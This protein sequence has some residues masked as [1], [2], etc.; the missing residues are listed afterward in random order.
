MTRRA[1]AVGR[2]RADQAVA[3]RAAALERRA[4][5]LAALANRGVAGLAPLA[6]APT[7][8]SLAELQVVAPS[9]ALGSRSAGLILAEGD[10][11]FDYPL[12][13]VL[14]LLEDVH[15]YD[16]ECLARASDRIENMAYASGQL[17]TLSRRLERLLRDGRAPKAILLSGGGNDV[18]GPEFGM[19]LNHAASKLPGL[20]E[21]VVEG[22]I[23]VRI[24]SAYV[25][26]LAAVTRLCQTWLKRPLPILLHGYDYPVPDG[27]G[28][29][30]GWG[31]LPGPWLEPGFLEKGYGHLEDRKA[32]AKQ[33]I[34]RFNL[35]LAGVAAAPEFGHVTYVNLRGTLSAGADYEDHWGNEMHPTARG[36]EM[37][38]GSFAEVL[39]RF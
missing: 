25:T 32:I 26:I 35:M 12:Y 16:V 19:L 8:P 7:L 29:F 15:G 27:R 24:R 9:F 13:D 14:D 18:V 2:Q 3:M 28:V 36:F 10:S 5:A 11:W 6:R 33:L 17:E 34:D 21:A 37:I 23:D 4:E 31:P 22:V 39:R 1:M 30:G 38:A 20:N